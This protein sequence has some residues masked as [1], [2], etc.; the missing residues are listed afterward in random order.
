MVLNGVKNGIAISLQNNRKMSDHLCN[1]P[2][3]NYYQK[4]F[5]RF[6]RIHKI[7]PSF[8]TNG[9]FIGTLSPTSLI[10]YIWDLLIDLSLFRETDRS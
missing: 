2:I 10:F 1:D 9:T 3:H 8:H 7:F 5:P 4:Y 6:I